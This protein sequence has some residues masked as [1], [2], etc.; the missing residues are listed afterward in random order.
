M[1]LATGTRLT[2]YDILAGLGAG[3]MS[4]YGHTEPRTS[5]SEAT[6]PHKLATGVGPR[7]R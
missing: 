7:R 2:A 1:T 4:P 3:G 5:R 6:C